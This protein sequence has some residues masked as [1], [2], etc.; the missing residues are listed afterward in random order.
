MADQTKKELKDVVAA[1]EKRLAKLEAENAKITAALAKK[2]K[3]FKG[4]KIEG[5]KFP[6]RTA[7]DVVM[8]ARDKG[9]RL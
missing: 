4:S 1:Q 8:E 2:D 9:K 3:D 5:K 7:N 6:G